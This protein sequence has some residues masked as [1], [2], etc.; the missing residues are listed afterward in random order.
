M[1]QRNVYVPCVETLAVDVG[2]FALLN[3]TV[4][5]PLTRVHVPVPIMAVFPASVV[6]NPHTFG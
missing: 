5:G 1:V 2:E 6:P 3:V 4:P